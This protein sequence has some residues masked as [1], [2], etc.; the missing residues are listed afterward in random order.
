M[1]TRRRPSRLSRRRRRRRA[2]PRIRS[3]RPPRP[4]TAMPDRG[5]YVLAI[6]GGGSAGFAAAITAAELGARV[7]LIGYGTIGGTCVNTG[8]IPSKILIRAMEPLHH[9]AAAMRFGG[10]RAEAR[11]E[12]WRAVELGK[13]ALVSSLRQAKYI[14]LL[15]AY[16][17]VAYF[18]GRARLSDGGVAV[19]GSVLKAD[20]VIITTGASPALPPIPG[21]ERVPYLTSTTA[22]ELDRL[23]RSLLVIGGGYIGC[24]L[25]Q[26][27]ARA[28]VIVT[29]VDIVPILS[30]G[31]PEISAALAGYLR[32]EGIVLREGVRPTAIRE[33]ACGVALDILADGRGE[34]IEAEQVLVS[35]RRRPNTAGLGLEEAGIELLPNGGVKVDDHMR[36]TRAGTYAA[37]DVTGRDQ[38]VYMAAYG[39][40]IAAENALNGDGRRYD[41]TAMPSVVFTDPQVASVGLTEA[42]ARA[43]GL[44]VKTSVLPLDQVPRALAARDARGLFKLVAEAGSGKLLGAHLLAPEGADSIQTAALAIKGGLTVGELAE[45]IFPYLTTVEGLK[46]TAQSF[47]KDVAKLSCCAG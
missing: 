4:S 36:T 39:A 1:T 2:T 7:A 12:D 15:P 40:R 35:T 45:T 24:E 10:I 25:G 29:I 14:D 26:L 21:I 43:K 47:Q 37:G 11:V 13:D 32:A 8:C 27:F 20:K 31:E 16:D 5:P 33:A 23:P 42:E 17:A 34:T 22:L 28:G 6:I 44:A 46:L 38:F 3:T 30:A 19:N 9:A 41:T 18:E